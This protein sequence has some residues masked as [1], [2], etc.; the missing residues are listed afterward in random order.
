MKSN[1]LQCRLNV[2]LEIIF[3]IMSSRIGA[4]VSGVEQRS[5]LFKT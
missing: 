2:F 3:L 4:N 1:I 5:N